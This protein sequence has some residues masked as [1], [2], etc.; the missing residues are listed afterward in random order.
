MPAETSERIIPK[1]WQSAKAPYNQWAVQADAVPTKV[2][3]EKVAAKKAPPKVFRVDVKKY[4]TGRE[5]D[6]IGMKIGMKELHVK[7][8]ISKDGKV[9]T[10]I[11]RDKKRKKA[12]RKKAKILKAEFAATEKKSKAQIKKAAAIPEKPMPAAAEEKA[13]EVDVMN[14]REFNGRKRELSDITK[15]INR[16]TPITQ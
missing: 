11:D 3:M 6:E 14:K 1:P 7:N 15:Q 9:Q 13:S 4:R 5:G 16:G 8:V 2:L 12:E 10:A